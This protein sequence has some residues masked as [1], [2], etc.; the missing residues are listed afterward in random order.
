[1]AA[2][3]FTEGPALH[4]PP[5]FDGIS[6]PFTNIPLNDLN[7]VPISFFKPR[8]ERFSRWWFMIPF[9]TLAVAFSVAIVVIETRPRQTTPAST[10][11]V[12]STLLISIEP[13]PTTITLL[14]SS[15]PDHLPTPTTFIVCTR[16]TKPG[17]IIPSLSMD[18][19]VVPFRPTPTT[20]IVTTRITKT[21]VAIVSPS[22][23]PG[24]SV[25]PFLP[26]S[27]FTAH[28]SELPSAKPSL[29]VYDST[30]TYIVT[31]APPAAASTLPEFSFTKTVVVTVN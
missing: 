30:T 28:V 20:T 27:A 25:I 15:G 4:N 29:Q 12:T 16:T 23:D 24:P 2:S 31:V 6:G 21:T 18:P 7:D 19:Y 5:P 22:L 11:Y 14:P 1:M 26:N 9:I 10:V 17:V 13:T 3:K 8:K